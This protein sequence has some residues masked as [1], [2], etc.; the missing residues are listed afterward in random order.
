MS[1]LF[2]VSQAGPEDAGIRPYALPGP[3]HEER[4]Q[5]RMVRMAYSYED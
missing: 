2:A 5:E 3:F 4:S 1:D